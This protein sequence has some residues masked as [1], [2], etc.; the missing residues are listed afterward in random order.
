M[1][2]GS[3]S[4]VRYDGSACLNVRS[5]TTACKLLTDRGDA[6]L[7]WS[8]LSNILWFVETCITSK[9]IFFDGTVPRETRDRALSEI[10]RFKRGGELQLFEVSSISF[11]D[12]RAILRAAKDAL[13]ESKLLLED[14]KID[15][16][17]DS[18][19]DQA[20]HDTFVEQ[21]NIVRTL[22]E[23]QRA[24][25]ALSWVSDA[26]RGSKCL[27]AMVANGDTALDAAHKLYEQHPKQ[28][29]LV[30]GAIINRFR[31]N[32]VNQLASY[33]R[34]AYVPNPEFEPLTQQHFNLFKDYLMQRLI[35]DVKTRSETN[36]LVENMRSENPLPPLGLYALMA[37]REP[38]RP[39]AILEM[40]YNEFR[41]DDGL[42]RLIWANTKG[43]ISLK[44]TTAADDYP[45]KIDQYF[46]DR[47]KTME[48]ALV[49]TKPLTSR[50]KKGR[51]YLVPAVLKGLVKAIPEA[52]GVGKAWDVVYAVIREIGTEASIPFLSD[53][54][55]DSGCDSYISHYEDFKWNLE[56]DDA[57][58]KGLASISDQVQRV[59]G[60]PLL[61]N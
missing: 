54:L 48:K 42:M 57:V 17:F 27:A 16:A 56:K 3:S 39:A 51:A 5:I 26:F 53:Y 38:N 10:D 21:L 59:F 37:T 8:D 43:G 19:V 25:L 23:A 61:W 14:F 36:L 35:D 1:L 32:Y 50:R 6:P 22:P 41:Q 47:Y 20:E 9:G 46:Y 2:Q 28:G 31:L 60:R 45:W 18:P 58:K 33:K 44:K 13:A 34:S 29:P 55:L 7:P 24:E 52:L 15:S 49:A 4:A 11:D 40:A 30:T 12:P